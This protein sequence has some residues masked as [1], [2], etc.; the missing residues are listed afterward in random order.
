MGVAELPVDI[1]WA[2][3]RFRCVS[4]P[5][6]APADFS[7]M[8]AQHLPLHSMPLG[9]AGHGDFLGGLTQ[10]KWADSARAQGVNTKIS[11][12]QLW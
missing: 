1:L 2:E 9:A 10:R 6:A 7:T 8:E 11:V 3:N 4:G 5:V 12:G